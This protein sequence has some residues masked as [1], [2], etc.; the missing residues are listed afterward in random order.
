MRIRTNINQLR[1]NA[2]RQFSNRNENDYNKCFGILTLCK[3]VIDP[4]VLILNENF[5]NN[6]L[7][8][9]LAVLIIFFLYYKCKALLNQNM[10]PTLQINSYLSKL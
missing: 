8:I 6:M 9:R 2:I 3:I 4:N 1:P 10:S 5:K 7:K